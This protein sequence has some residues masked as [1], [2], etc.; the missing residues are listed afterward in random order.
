LQNQLVSSA[1][2]ISLNGIIFNKDMP[3][4][5]INNTIAKEGDLIANNTKI[6]SIKRDSV[7][8]NDGSK[9]FELKLRE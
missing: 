9:D 7:I 8:L 6:V 4:A 2:G 3:V 1:Q 5:V